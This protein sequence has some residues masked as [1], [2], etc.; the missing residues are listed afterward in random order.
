MIEAFEGKP[1]DDVAIRLM[2]SIKE[3]DPD[4][5]VFNWECSSGYGSK[6]FPEQEKNV[7]IF[8]KLI[9]DK[10]FMAMFSDF[11]LKALVANWKDKWGLGPNPFVQTA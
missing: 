2:N 5:V 4:C 10:G 3:L 11:S 8:L 9:I 6:S 1:K 7:A